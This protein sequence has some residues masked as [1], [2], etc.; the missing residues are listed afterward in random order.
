MILKIY[1]GLLN[2]WENLLSVTL[3]AYFLFPDVS[4]IRKFFNTLCFSFTILCN[5]HLGIEF[6]QLDTNHKFFEK[7]LLDFC[8]RKI[9]E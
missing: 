3:S 1:L 9:Y 2:K 6:K 8:Y 5:D 7:Y 4:T